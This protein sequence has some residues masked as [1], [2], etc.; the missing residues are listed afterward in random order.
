[1]KASE[2]D[3]FRL[4]TVFRSPEETLLSS[5]KFTTGLVGMD[6]EQVPLSNFARLLSL[7]GEFDSLYAHYVDCWQRRNHP[8]VLLLF[9]DDMKEELGER[10]RRVAEH[11][12]VD[13]DADVIEKVT[14]QSTLAFMSAPERARRFAVPS[15]LR[16]QMMAKLGLTEGDMKGTTELVRR[17]AARSGGDVKTLPD[18]VRLQLR[19]LWDRIVLPATNRT[20][21]EDMRQHFRA[22][23]AR[24]RGS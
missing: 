6:H 16:T 5:W 2:S 23:R 13:K 1:M 24:R 17:R 7:A 22:E 9:F 14:Q 20:S 10:V 18:A 15:E 21:V 4:V 3:G 8:D 11:L 19:Q 12:E